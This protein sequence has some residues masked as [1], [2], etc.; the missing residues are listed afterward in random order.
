MMS[1]I[2]VILFHHL[3]GNRRN[4]RLIF[5]FVGYAYPCYLG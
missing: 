1:E 4:I 5:P 2:S 3:L